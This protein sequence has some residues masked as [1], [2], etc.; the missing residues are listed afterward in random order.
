MERKGADDWDV[1]KFEK[2]AKEYMSMRKEL[3]Q[4]LAAKCGE[5]WTVVEQRVSH[6]SHP[7]TTSLY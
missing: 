2:I 6:V 3:W 5:K 7:A 1:R 4:P